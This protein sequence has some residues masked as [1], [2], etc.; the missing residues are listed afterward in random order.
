[1]GT[2]N[3]QSTISGSVRKL[4]DVEGILG[5]QD[6]VGVVKGERD[7]VDGMHHFIDVEGLANGE[8]EHLLGLMDRASPLSAG[9]N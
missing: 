8:G 6:I 5:D 2:R 1:M 7:L 9:S 4:E 3:F